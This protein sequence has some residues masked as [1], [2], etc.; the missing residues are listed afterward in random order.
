MQPASVWEPPDGK[1]AVPAALRWTAEAVSKDTPS[2]LAGIPEDQERAVRFET[3]EY[4]R[5]TVRELARGAGNLEHEGDTA[6]QSRVQMLAC[7]YVQ[8]FYQFTSVLQEDIKVV[9]L[10]AAL[11]ACKMGDIPRKMR[12]LLRTH[13]FL[14]T[15]NGELELGDEEVK[16][17]EKRIVK[18][19]FVI[20]RVVCFHVDIGLPIN[21]IDRL[22]DRILTGLSQ[23]K[24]WT[25]L[26]AKEGVSPT[27]FAMQKK[28]ELVLVAK[29]FLADQ[30][31]GVTPLLCPT[32]LCSASA[33]LMA[34]RYKLRGIS[35]DEIMEVLL[36]DP[37]II[38]EAQKGAVNVRD[39]LESAIQET[40]H[41]FKVKTYA[42]NPKPQVR[43]APR[44]TGP[45]P[46]A[47]VSSTVAAPAGSG[48]ATADSRTIS[49]NSVPHGA[50]SQPNLG[51]ERHQGQSLQAKDAAESRRRSRSPARVRNLAD[52]A[53]RR[54]DVLDT[55][56]AGA[57]ELMSAGRV[58]KDVGSS[59]STAATIGMN[60]SVR[61]VSD[62]NS[63]A[64][65]LPTS[66]GLSPQR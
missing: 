20:L 11:C 28:S 35:K 39:L 29:A 59:D 33:A 53:R 36:K 27:A 31:T 43:T 25:A 24:T 55:R 66:T 52:Q 57:S 10:A 41:I 19:E 42:H 14:R 18:T 50:D 34:I 8:I 4:A 61:S 48:A 49:A 26:A 5:L 13:N 37:Q 45:T 12:D 51:H 32:I 15:R 62:D 16:A 23:N 17:L 6:M 21:H 40:L 30:F 47:G 63:A 54:A 2:R 64:G 1:G 9:A 56:N 3:C 38:R 65:A 60:S 58:T 44:E 22:M 46:T 7:F